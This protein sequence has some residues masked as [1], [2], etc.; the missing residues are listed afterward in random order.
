MIKWTRA[1]TAERYPRPLSPLGWSNIHA[2]FDRGVRFFSEFIGVPIPEKEQLATTFSG[3]VFANEAAFDFKNQFKITLLGSEK[4][5]LLQKSVLFLLGTRHPMRSLKSFINWAKKP[6]K[7]RPIF[8]DSIDSVQFFIS[9]QGLL[10][11]LERISDDLVKAWPKTLDSF[12]KE[13]DFALRMI[14]AEND[15]EKLLKIGDRLRKAM[16]DYINP[17]LVIFAVKEIASLGLSEISRLAG[18]ENFREVPALLGTGLEKN[19]T[20]DLNRKLDNLSRICFSSKLFQGDPHS[21]ELS[22]FHPDHQNEIND[23]LKEFGHLTSS[24]DIKDPTW[25]EDEKS[26]LGIL[27]GRS[28]TEFS[29]RDSKA[30]LRQKLENAINEKL[31]TSDLASKAFSSLVKI[32]RKFMMI[33]EEHHFHTGRVIPPT[34]KLVL[35]LGKYLS[36]RT[37][38]DGPED[39]F[40]L[41]DVEVRK[42]ISD[43]SFSSRKE[44]ISSRKQ[45]FITGLENGPPELEN[46]LQK[47]PF[48]KD[49]QPEFPKIKSPAAPENLWK[50]LGVSPGKAE[51]RIRK[52]AEPKDLTGIQ[53]GEIML[54]RSPDPFFTVAFSC[55]GG[56]IAE[57]G[58]MLSHGAVAAREYGLPAAFGIKGAWKAL[59]AG[60]L[61]EIDG[62]TGSV[63]VIEKA[64]PL[65]SS[66]MVKTEISNF[67][68]STK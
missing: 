38:M 56:L 47:E 59:C 58:A 15:P 37:V 3:W 21:I 45:D 60:D 19:V 57:T 35:K 11:Y 50:G 53:P 64:C 62:G 42:I 2:V 27:F 12:E 14:T 61:V 48:S 43:K 34:R 22:K 25:G 10:L 68:D 32:L 17:D 54:V 8:G 29:I 52:V 41:T 66:S 30:D 28:Q 16:I 5:V 65:S 33:D 40:W 23:F 26:F 7:E 49:S 6:K 63:K 9:V 36:D 55:L 4:V 67:Q 24:W 13:T 44:L 31:N 51:G 39:I 18:V 1:L 20:L 46:G